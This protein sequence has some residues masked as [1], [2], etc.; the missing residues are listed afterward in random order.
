MICIILPV[1]CICSS[2]P[3]FAQEEEKKSE[4]TT[5][6][7]GNSAFVSTNFSVNLRSGYNQMLWHPGFR[8]DVLGFKTEGLQSW[9]AGF[10]IQYKAI[11]VLFYRNEGPFKNTE[12]QNELFERNVNSPTALKEIQIGV[13]FASIPAFRK[14]ESWFVQGIGKLRYIHTER[15]FFGDVIAYTPFAYAPSN[16]EITRDGKYV[17]FKDISIINAG[18]TVSFQTKFKDD[19]V[20]VLVPAKYKKD[21]FNVRAGYFASS[22]D[23]PSDLD[24]TWRLAEDMMVIYETQFRSKGLVLGVEPVSRDIPGFNLA[25]TGHWGFYCR[26]K[27]R[28]NRDFQIDPDKDLLYAGGVIDMWFNWYPY[29]EKQNDF[30]VTVGAQW[31]RRIFATEISPT[32]GTWESEDLYS[33]IAAMR[34]HF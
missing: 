30:L 14:S 34:M 5:N 18:D 9:E 8:R 11:P 6:V 19:E 26:V 25:L 33:L 3:V 31:D 17:D 23:R 24:R 27:N 2:V 22:W 21:E 28:V 32:T 29:G 1:V 15:T 20:S 13:F 16:I 10:Q 12:T 4:L 7:L